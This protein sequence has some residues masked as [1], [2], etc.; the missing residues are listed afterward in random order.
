MIFYSVTWAYLLSFQGP[1]GWQSVASAAPA[2]ESIAQRANYFDFVANGNP[3]FSSISWEAAI[4]KN[5]EE[6]LFASSFEVRCC[7]FFLARNQYFY[8]I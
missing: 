6:E 5:I 1:L 4:Q 3:E 2:G 8:F 7:C